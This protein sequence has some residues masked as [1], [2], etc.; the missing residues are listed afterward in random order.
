MHLLGFVMYLMLCTRPDLCT[1]ISIFIIT[2]QNYGN[3]LKE[4]KYISKVLKTWN[5]LL[6]KII[7]MA[8]FLLAILIQIGLEVSLKKKILG[9]CLKAFWMRQQSSCHCLNTYDLD[10]YVGLRIDETKPRTHQRI[11]RKLLL[12]GWLSLRNIWTIQRSLL[13]PCNR[14]QGN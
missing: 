1:P 9:T 11:D 4:F 7:I 3:V 5:Y 13:T 12:D 10:I 2:T 8:I 14:A 6:F